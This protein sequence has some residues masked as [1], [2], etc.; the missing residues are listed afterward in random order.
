MDAIRPVDSLIA[1]AIGPATLAA[2]RA[3]F[4]RWVSP[5]DAGDGS[6]MPHHT[7]FRPPASTYL[8]LPQNTC[9][10]LYTTVCNRKT[11]AYM[12]RKGA[13]II[14][15]SLVERGVPYLVGVSG[16]GIL[17]LL[18]A[19]Y[20]RRD[21][22]TTLTTHDERIAGF[23]ADA[24][25]R[26]RGE[27]LATYTSCGPG[28]VNIV[29]AIAGAFQD[30]SAMLA[31]TGNV[32]TQQFNRGPFQETGRYFQGDYTSVIRPYVKRSFQAV[33][34]EMLPLMMS[35]AFG[36]MTSGRPGPVNIDVP[37]NVFVEEAI[38][39]PAYSPSNL[40]T[41]S[42]PA[43]SREVLDEAARLLRRAERPVILVGNGAFGPTTRDLIVRLAD[44][45]QIPIISTP[46][47]KGVVD[48]N[49]DLCLGPIGRNG[50]FAANQAARNSDVLLALGTRFDDRTTSSWIPGV[51][52]S[53]PPTKL[54]H[55]DIDPQEIG[56]NYPPTLG[57]MA[58]VT[59]FLIGLIPV[60]RDSDSP[61]QARSRWIQDAAGW[62]QKW[63]ADLAERQSDDMVP[64]RP[65][66]LVHELQRALPDDAIV[67]ADV[68]IHHNWLLQQM[69]APSRG[70]FLQAWGFAAM[71][72]G[73]G[74]VIGAKLAAPDQPV[75]TVCGDGGFLMHANAVA[76]AVECDL[77]VVWLVWN[78]TGYGSIRGQQSTFFGADRE[79]GT[80]F[81]RTVTGELL[82]SDF[83]AMARS[84]G[85]EGVRVE[86]PADV[87]EAV[88]FALKSGRPTVLDVITDASIAAP[89]TGSWDLPPLRGPEPD[90]GW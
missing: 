53:I 54:I 11:G 87:A 83:A 33:R 61:L 39:D 27:P 58:D 1:L 64:I 77:P 3:A 65:D 66:R 82:S 47:G 63:H 29:M 52:F 86:K 56:R 7:W 32:P 2:C 49:L 40:A 8:D 42:R 45:W 14:V 70:R 75:L 15:D 80:R 9:S 72:F 25:F 89:G 67:L 31:I 48:E 88:D 41:V 71:G 6:L 46:L 10:L 28:S 51:T 69:A 13:E 20:D 12:G 38:E 16:H 85:A 43:A 68:G 24:Y 73:V 4:D 79:I 44:E 36:L 18:D 26:V 21:E 30:S 5:A 23:I 19:A 74:G 35:Q 76:T 22:I 60:M 50:T 59:E 37:L 34:P 78:N 17:G 57:I 62:K 90:Y 55:V 84:M 81:R